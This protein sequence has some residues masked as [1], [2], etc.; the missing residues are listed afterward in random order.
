MN[1]NLK[2]IRIPDEVTEIGEYAFAGCYMAKTISIPP[3]VR[4]IGETS[5]DEGDSFYAD[6]TLPEHLYAFIYRFP[7]LCTVNRR[8]KYV[9]WEQHVKQHA[10]EKEKILYSQKSA[11][12]K[13]LACRKRWNPVNRMRLMKEIAC[14]DRI[15]SGAM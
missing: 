15:L 1:S 9:L 13:Q 8:N 7:P 3:S 5:F 11:Y 6:I 10:V 12:E 4:K 14:L 2:T